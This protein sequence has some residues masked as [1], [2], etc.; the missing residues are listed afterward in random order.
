[1]SCASK[2][3]RTLIR[4]RILVAE[5]HPVL[6]S[7]TIALLTS[8]FD[9][10]G[11]VADGA[12]L[13]AEASRLCPDVIVSAITLPI[14]NGIDAVHQL[15]KSISPFRIVFLTVHAER[16]FINACVAEG[17]L[18]YVLKSQMKAHLIPAVHAALAGTSYIYPFAAK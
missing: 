6:R 9:V 12:A 13:V 3:R 18:G 16:E 15:R 17:A 14:L 11:S 2:R 8:H 1:M 5:S 10:V 7:A 4:P